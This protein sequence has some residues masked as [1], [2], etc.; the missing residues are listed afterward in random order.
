MAES[1]E[2]LTLDLGSGLIMS[3]SH[4]L[5]SALGVKP[6]LKKKTRN[7]RI[8]SILVYNELKCKDILKGSSQ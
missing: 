5:G 8:K 4:T 3:L 7:T 2:R 6:T 1:V